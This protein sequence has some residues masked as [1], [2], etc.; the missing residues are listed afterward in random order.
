MDREHNFW[1]PLHIVGYSLLLCVMFFVLVAI[2][3]IIRNRLLK[4]KQSQSDKNTSASVETF[5]F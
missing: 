4:K 1:T 3:L 5:N 2:V